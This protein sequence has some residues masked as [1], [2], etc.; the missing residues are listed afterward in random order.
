M[1]CFAALAMTSMQSGN[2]VKAT[3]HPRY[4]GFN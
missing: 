4:C 3:N 1:D 2:L